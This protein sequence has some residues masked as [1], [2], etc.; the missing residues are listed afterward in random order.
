MKDENDPIP[1]PASTRRLGPIPAICQPSPAEEFGLIEI[2]GEPGTV[3]NRVRTTVRWIVVELERRVAQEL[4][5]IDAGKVA[6]SRWPEMRRGMLVDIQRHLSELTLPFI[7]L[8]LRSLPMADCGWPAEI[9]G[10]GDLRSSEMQ[11]GNI[12]AD[13]RLLA[14]GLD[15]LERDDADALARWLRD[16]ANDLDPW[17]EPT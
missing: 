3:E 1:S 10:Y 13:M 12:S 6:P 2:R 9:M 16:T 14:M 5:D 7:P 11:L 8:E 17:G 15:R 4:R